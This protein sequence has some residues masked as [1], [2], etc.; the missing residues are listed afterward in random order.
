MPVV[1]CA[2]THSAPKKVLSLGHKSK[3]VDELNMRGEGVRNQPER[4]G[5]QRSQLR[6]A[7]HFTQTKMER[8][9]VPF[10]T[11]ILFESASL[12][13]ARLGVPT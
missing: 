2:V 4:T 5:Y 12:K 1:T 11:Y 9:S 7:L 6:Q 13:L 10:F 8:L 3:G